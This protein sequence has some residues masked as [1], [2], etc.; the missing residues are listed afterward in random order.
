MKGGSDRSCARRQQRQ[1][2]GLGYGLGI[3]ITIPIPIATRFGRTH[4]R[5]HLARDA[6][7]GGGAQHAQ[8]RREREYQ[9]YLPHGDASF[10]FHGYGTLRKR[11]RAKPRPE[12]S[13]PAL[14]PFAGPPTGEPTLNC[15][16]GLTVMWKTG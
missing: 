15:K 1:R 14:S 11:E 12:G 4:R 7:P 9:K 2:T 8:N 6:R 13:Y 16:K 5:N 10:S 3:V